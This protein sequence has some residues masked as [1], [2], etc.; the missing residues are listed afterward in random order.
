MGTVF[1]IKVALQGVRPPVWRRVRVPASLTLRRLHDVIQAVMGWHGFHLHLFE[2]NDRVYG[3]TDLMPDDPGTGERVY[4]DRNVRLSGL[5]ERGN[6]AIIYTYDLGDDWR[7]DV[8]LEE[9]RSAAPGVAYPEFVT[10]KGA[11]PPE[12]VGGP[13]GYADFVEIMADPNHPD[14]ADTAEWVGAKT[15]DPKALDRAA[16][17]TRL[18]PIRSAARKGPKRKAQAAP[19]SEQSEPSRTSADGAIA[20]ILAML[21]DGAEIAEGNLSTVAVALKPHRSRPAHLVRL[22]FPLETRLPS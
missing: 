15:F 18:D 14:Y 19:R 11:C 21:R 2:A 17:E 5:V 10:G 1:Q 12:D 7:H 9:T 22:L 4:S 3:P 16:I 8:I 13:L 6:T 20:F